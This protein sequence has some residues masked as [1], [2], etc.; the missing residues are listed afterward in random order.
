MRKMSAVIE[1]HT[2]YRIPRL[3]YGK[4]HRHISLRSGMRLHIS[5]LTSE[6]L[7]SSLYGKI[8]HHIDDLTSAV[9]S[10]RGIS[11]GVL[12]RKHRAHCGHDRGAYPV[13]RCYKFDM[14]GLTLKLRRYRIR[15]PGIDLPYVVNRIH[16]IFLSIF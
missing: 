7:L 16:G 15:D 12:I 5:V 13:F 3:A 2:H 9:I 11:L 14:L 8:F 4:L 6:K 10:L 1:A